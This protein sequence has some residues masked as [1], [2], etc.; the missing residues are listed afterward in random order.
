MI[1][2]KMRVILNPMPTQYPR[3]LTNYSDRSRATD[4]RTLWRRARRGVPL[5]P[6]TQGAARQAFPSDRRIFVQFSRTETVRAYAPFFAFL[7]HHLGTRFPCYLSL[8]LA[9]FTCTITAAHARSRDIRPSIQPHA[10]SALSPE[11]STELTRWYQA[12]GQKRRNETFGNLVIRAGM[13]QIGKPYINPPDPPGAVEE[14]VVELR[15]FECVSFVES[16]L[17]MAR[18]V[19]KNENIATGEACFVRELEQQRYR[20]GIRQ[21]YNSRLHYFSEWLTDNSARGLLDM[22]INRAL[23]A[24]TLPFRFNFMSTHPQY[25]PPLSNTRILHGIQ[26]TENRI[27]ATPMAI[28]SDNTL[29]KGDPQFQDGDVVAI[30]GNKKGLLISH[31]GFVHVDEKGKMHILHASSYQ[32]RV[33]LTTAGVANYIRRRS[34]R[35]GVIAARPQ[36]GP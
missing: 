28:I 18:C 10:P 11:Q 14:L 34:E 4:T 15:S 26:A 24:E 23:G 2:A 9:V 35:R 6:S 8:Y 1:H 21:D 25:Y 20:H 5:K 3:E 16:T 17:A 12:I 36:L 13:L 7:A 33:L 30:V 31:T 19:W 32:K 22:K 27:S 29:A